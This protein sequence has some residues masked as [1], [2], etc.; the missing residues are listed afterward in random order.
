MDRLPERVRRALWRNNVT[1]PQQVVALYP[2]RLLKLPGFG[3]YCL[4][5]VEQVF[6]PGQ[7]YEPPKGI[8]HRRTR[9]VAAVPPRMNSTIVRLGKPA[10]RQWSHSGF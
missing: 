2:Q 4:R 10:S 7:R 1:T 6:F 9:A 5:Q 3:I 8:G